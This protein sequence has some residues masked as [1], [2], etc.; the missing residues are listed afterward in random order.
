MVNRSIRSAPD[1]LVQRLATIKRHQT[2]IASE[3]AAHLH[4]VQLARA[5]HMIDH[6]GDHFRRCI[7]IVRQLIDRECAAS[8][9]PVQQFF[10]HLYPTRLTI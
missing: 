8:F 5:R 9:Q 6:P 4:R 10:Q 2:L 1:S 7:Q 3:I